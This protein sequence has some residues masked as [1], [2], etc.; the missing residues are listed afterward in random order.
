MAAQ[1]SPPVTSSRGNFLS[2]AWPYAAM[3]VLAL[4]AVT[5]MTLAPQSSFGLWQLLAPVFALICI[6]TQWH[7]AP[8]KGMTH[9]Q[10]IL[11]QVLHWGAFALAMQIFRFPFYGFAGSA[12]VRGL[13]AFQ[14]LS[15]STLLAGI[16]LDW[17]LFVVGLFMLAGLV[18]L[19]LFDQATIVIVLLLA[20]ALLAMYGLH[21]LTKRGQQ[22]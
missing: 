5:A 4:V 1:A 12:E 20:V 8:A 18:L 7:R 19:G 15:L 13:A 3:L 2:T 22:P 17:R 16:Y 21:W 6:A 11:R 14:L 10:L 9:M